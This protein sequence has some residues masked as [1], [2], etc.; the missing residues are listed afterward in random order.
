MRPEPVTVK[1]VNDG[2]VLEHDGGDL[3]VDLPAFG[4]IER[5]ARTVEQLVD[6]RLAV[7]GVIERGLAEVEAVQVAVGI[8]ASAPGEHV[9]LELA[10][11]GHVERGREFGRLNLDVEAGV[12]DHRLHD[13]RDLLRVRRGRSHQRKARVGDARLRQQGLGAGHVALRYGNVLG[14]V[15]IGGSDPLIADVGLAVHRHLHDTVAIER[16]L[17]SFAHPDIL[18][19][20]IFLREIAFPDIDG[21]ALI[22]D[23]GDPGDLAAG[24]VLERGYVGAGHAFDDVELSRAQIGETHRRIDDREI[25]DPVEMNLALVPVVRVA[26]EHALV[27]RDA[28][29]EAERSRAYGLGAELVALGLRRLG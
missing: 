5:A 1:K 13:L 23:F 2:P 14:V 8:G 3:L 21:N 10:L 7:A 29:D 11:V 12:L 17:E 19:E 24:V 25:N 4:R 22:A 20:R 16:E 15:R 26:L 28:F 9:G 27:L 6:L 18:A